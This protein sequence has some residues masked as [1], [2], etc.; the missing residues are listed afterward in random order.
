MLHPQKQR[1]RVGGPHVFK[2]V[3]FVE[4]EHYFH[5]PG[6][7]AVLELYIYLF[8]IRMLIYMCKDQWGLPLY[9][10]N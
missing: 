10:T 3:H 5:S 9:P 8:C 2:A 1:G 4:T 7:V 6:E